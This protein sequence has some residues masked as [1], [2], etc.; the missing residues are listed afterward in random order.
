[1]IVPDLPTFLYVPRGCQ[2]QSTALQSLK[3]YLV[4][5]TRKFDVLRTTSGDTSI[6]CALAL[7]KSNV[8]KTAAQAMR[9]E[10][11]ARRI[12]VPDKSGLSFLSLMIN[13]FIF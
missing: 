8:P 3:R 10:A 5:L 4:P 2:H 12:D 13:L 9:T 7:D 6:D 1:M 11:L